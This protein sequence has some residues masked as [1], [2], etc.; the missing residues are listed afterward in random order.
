MFQ[1]GMTYYADERWTEAEQVFL[2]IISQKSSYRQNGCSA[3]EMVKIVINEREGR[4]ALEQ[5]DLHRA[6]R[7]FRETGNLERIVHVEDLIQIDLLEERSQI[8]IENGRFRQAAWLYDQLLRKHGDDIRAAGWKD[9]QASCWRE[10]LVPVFDRGLDALDN[11]EWWNAKKHFSEVMCGDPDYR[12][13]GQSA[14]VLLEQCKQEIRKEGNEA[15]D[16]GK[17]EVALAAYKEIMDMRKIAQV[18][19]L[20]HLQSQG[21]KVAKE[22]RRAEKWAKAAAVY[23]WLTTLN[24]GPEK[25]Q[26]WYDLAVKCAEKARLTYLFDKGMSAI[27]QKDWVEAERR[28]A[29]AKE[30]DPKFQYKG[31]RVLRM[32]RMAAVKQ[33]LAML[34]PQ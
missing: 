21:E 12:R 8:H 10:E 1:E 33:R 25:H 14:A 11:K 5:G 3:K 20:M 34:L 31:E 27:N 13:R 16:K 7:H 9:A 19:E 15:L 18:E 30:I 24:L 28:F 2:A 17:L 4:L 6:V 26:Q 29:E 32:Y 22:Y 23:E